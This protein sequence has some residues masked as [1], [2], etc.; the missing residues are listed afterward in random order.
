MQK[1]A[2]GCAR[3]CAAHADAAHAH[4]LGILQAPF[5]G[6]SDQQI[7]RLGCHGRHH[8][9]DLLGAADAG[10][11]QAVRAGLGIGL[12]PGNGVVEIGPAHEE[13]LRTPDQQGAAACLVDGSAGGAQP[14]HGV[15]DAA[16]GV[17]RIACR[18]LDGQPCHAG[19][20]GHANALCH[21]LRT[22]AE[23]A[24]K[25]RVHGQVGGRDQ[26]AQMRQGHVARDGAIGPAQRPCMARAG[27]G[28]RLEAQALQHAGAAGVPWIGQYK[29]ALAVQ[30]PEA[31]T[32]LFGG[33]GH[34]TLRFDS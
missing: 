25:V 3:Q 2:P 32:F 21:L 24:L 12:E 20:Q 30:G 7:H 5:A 19:V 4:G 14:G 13:I 8:G 9:T 27:A 29:A 23:A 15:L 26:G 6:P 34:G 33:R 16:Q 1:A 22:Q 10:C 28:Q 17:G 18:I 31:G 11:V